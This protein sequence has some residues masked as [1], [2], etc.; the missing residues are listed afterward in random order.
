MERFVNLVVLL[1]SISCFGCQSGVLSSTDSG[2]LTNQRAQV[3]VNAWVSGFGGT[4]TV[5][6]IQEIP[7]ENKAT[8]TVQLRGFT[9]PAGYSAGIRYRN[10]EVYNGPALATFVHY[11]D[12]RWFMTGFQTDQGFNSVSWRNVSVEVR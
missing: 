4:A 11:N 2:K 7:Q 8:A 3:A 1:V 9:I 5:Q 12:G 10:P 6:G